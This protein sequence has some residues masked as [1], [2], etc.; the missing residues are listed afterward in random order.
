MPVAW[1]K[2][3]SVDGGPKGLVFTTTMGAAIDLASEGMRRLLVNA[4]YWATGL[5]AAIPAKSAVEI[6]GTYEPTAFGF[7]TAKKGLTPAKLR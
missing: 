3:Y 4:C 6:V 2:T 5:E 1:T 7:G